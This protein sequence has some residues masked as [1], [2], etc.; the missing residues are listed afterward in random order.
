M[1]NYGK[2]L[3]LFFFTCG[4]NLSIRLVICIKY[5]NNVLSLL[6]KT[7]KINMVKR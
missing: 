7:L 6:L 5:G 2:D 1:I 3:L 4:A